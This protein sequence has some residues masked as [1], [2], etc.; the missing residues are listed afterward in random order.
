MEARLNACSSSSV[1]AI[2][3]NILTH[4]GAWKGGRGPAGHAAAQTAAA[5]P[6]RPRDAQIDATALGRPA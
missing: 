4:D 2:V 5:P 6:A 3:V 1:G